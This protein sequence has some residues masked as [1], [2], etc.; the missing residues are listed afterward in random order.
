MRRHSL[1]L[2]ALLAS[3]SVNGAEPPP[4]SGDNPLVTGFPNIPADAR[5]V[6]ER[7]ASC[8]HFAGEING[9]GGERDKEVATT[10]TE[11]NCATIDKDVA[12][13]RRKYAADPDV[14]KALDRAENP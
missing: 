7:L 2:I 11:L 3:A 10:M 6:A 4:A 13:I 9:D 14:N 1:L 5:R 8:T 12:A